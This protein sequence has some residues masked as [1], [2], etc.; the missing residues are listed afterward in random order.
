MTYNST[1]DKKVSVSAAQA[2][3][4]GI[5]EDGGSDLLTHIPDSSYRR[6]D[7]RTAFSSIT[8]ENPRIRKEAVK[9]A[10]GHFYRKTEIPDSKQNRA[11][12]G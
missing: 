3:A 10:T 6:P 11:V 8:P 12:P 4:Q 7:D 1:T 5:S 2:I 9:A